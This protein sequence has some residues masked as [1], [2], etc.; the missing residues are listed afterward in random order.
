MDIYFG[1]NSS[2]SNNIEAYM[3]LGHINELKSYISSE[4]I[5][6]INSIDL[7]KSD[8]EISESAAQKISNIIK[9]A[10]RTRDSSIRDNM[11]SQQER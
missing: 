9:S 10:E 8:S 2:T 5:E 1:W 7:T 6:Y 4:D 3:V 11:V